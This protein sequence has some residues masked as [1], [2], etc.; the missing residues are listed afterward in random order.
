MAQADTLVGS[1][2]REMLSLRE[3]WRQLHAQQ[4]LCQEDSLRTRLASEQVQVLSR[5]LEL[6]RA[7]RAMTHGGLLHDPLSQAFLQELTRRS[8]TA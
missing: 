4:A 3:R 6:Q 1:L 2:C 7:A 8:L 5:R